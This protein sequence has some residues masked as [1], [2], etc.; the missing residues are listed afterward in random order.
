SHCAAACVIARR[1]YFLK[2]EK[3]KY[4]TILSFPNN[5][6]KN[7]SNF[8]KWRIITNHLKKQYLFQDKIEIVKADR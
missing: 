4:D 1:G 8:S 2:T 5:L 7:Q 3:P 6:N